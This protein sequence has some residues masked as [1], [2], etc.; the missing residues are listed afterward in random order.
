MNSHLFF[1]KYVGFVLRISARWVKFTTSGGCWH[2][3]LPGGDW[4]LEGD[5]MLR[6]MMK[7]LIVVISNSNLD[8]LVYIMIVCDCP[9]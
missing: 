7:W 6:L 4:V 2:V 3:S 5:M 1:Y 8:V 9:R